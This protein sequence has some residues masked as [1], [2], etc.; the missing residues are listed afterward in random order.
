MRHRSS[1]FW[2]FCSEL[3][4]I[5]IS[6]PQTSWSAGGSASERTADVRYSDSS[7]AVENDTSDGPKHQTRSD[8]PFDAMVAGGGVIMGSCATGARTD[9]IIE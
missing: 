3:S 6:R 2:L 4:A 7:A 9:E 8:Q 5:G 1:L